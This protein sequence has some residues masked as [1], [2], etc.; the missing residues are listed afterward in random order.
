MP[1]SR[2]LR[3]LMQKAVEVFPHRL[4]VFI[5]LEVPL[6]QTLQGNAVAI[7]VSSRGQYHKSPY[8]RRSTPQAKRL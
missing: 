3:L 4:R 7:L 2:Q 6:Q 1:D 8:P 5:L